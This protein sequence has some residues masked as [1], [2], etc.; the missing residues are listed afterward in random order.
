MKMLFKNFV[1]L[2]NIIFCWQDMS[3]T[4]SQ[5]ESSYCTQFE[6]VEARTPLSTLCRR[7]SFVPVFYNPDIHNSIP[8]L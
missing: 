2:M 5:A 6:M 3:F 4:T 7:Q 8:S 1:T